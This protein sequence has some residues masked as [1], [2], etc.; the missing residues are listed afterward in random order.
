MYVG[1]GWYAC[2]ILLLVCI[3]VLQ[4]GGESSHRMKAAFFDHANPNSQGWAPQWLAS[5]SRLATCSYWLLL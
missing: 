1:L 4:E 3:S 2:V 5:L